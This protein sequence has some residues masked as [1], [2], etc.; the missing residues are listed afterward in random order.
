MEKGVF[1]QVLPCPKCGEPIEVNKERKTFRCCRQKCKTKFSQRKHTFFFGSRLNCAQI[2][3]LGYLW[4]NKCSQTQCMNQT[5]HSSNTVS[6][7]HSHFRQLVASTLDEAD[8]EI[9]GENVIVQIDETK[10]GKR[11]YNRGHRVDGVWI[12][13]GVELTEER[14]IFVVHVHDRT[15]ETILPLI[16]KHVKPGS[17]IHTDKFKSYFQI[18][19]LLGFQH[20]TVN[21]KKHFKDPITG[22]NT[23][24]I[25]GNNNALKIAI[26]PRNR[27]K[28]STN[29]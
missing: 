11:K 21:H 13:A 5:G 26:K 12:L 7:F 2:L 15:A 6:S 16:Q 29:I 23:N 24:T 14:R 28:G 20:S 8:Q 4:L 17:I 10:L 18:T 22:V 3:H 25:E 9:G 19:P 1:Y 27:T